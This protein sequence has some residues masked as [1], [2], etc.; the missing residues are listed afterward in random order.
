MADAPLSYIRFSETSGDS[1]VD[2]SGRAGT[3]TAGVA[4]DEPGLVQCSDGSAVRF[5]GAPGGNIDFGDILA[6]QG[7]TSFSLEAWYVSNDFHGQMIRKLTT[8]PSSNGYT[9]TLDNN[10]LSFYRYINGSTNSAS[11]DSTIAGTSSVHH[12]VG[13]YDGDNELICL[14]VDGEL[15][16]CG[17][18]TASITTDGDFSLGHWQ[19][20]G[21]LDEVAVYGAPLT[22]PQVRSHYLVGTG[23]TGR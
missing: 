15:V 9:L 5:S 2:Q 8:S 20:A 4:L 17:G 1:V 23:Q 7:K 21:V 6:F 13:T 16:E 10:R 12:V 18:S 3:F 14:Y 22:L 11:A 19:Y